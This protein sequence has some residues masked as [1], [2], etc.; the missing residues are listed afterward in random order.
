VTARLD[1]GAE[2]TLTCNFLFLC[3]GYYDYAGGYM[4][5][6]P[7]A[8]RFGKHKIIHPQLWNDT[9][10]YAG[11]RIVVIGSGA[12][13]VTLVPELA[14]KA[15]SV[16]MLQRSPTYIVSMPSVDPV[17]RWLR[18]KLP[19]GMAYDVTRFKNVSLA[20][21]IFNASRRFPVKMKE[22][23]VNQ[24]KARVGDTVDVAAHFTPTY[25]PWD[26]RL[27]LVPDADLFE[28]LRTG[29]AEIVTDHIETFT[30]HGIQLKSG[31]LLEADLV[32]S[33]TGL[34]LLFAGGMKLFVDG[35]EVDIG[36]A[37]NYKGTM[38]SDV[39]NFAV[40]LG[41][42]NASWT[43]KADLVCTYV[44][45]LLAYMDQHG[46]KQCVPRV[47]ERGEEVPLIDFSSGYV[48]RAIAHMPKQGPAAPW[49]LRQNYF[50]D[51]VGLRH[52]KIDDGVIQFSRGNAAKLKPQKRRLL[53]SAL[54]SL[55]SR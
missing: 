23:F 14:K 28:A 31:R 34:K 30:E 51:L 4:P 13:A 42:T 17:A 19:A 7:G 5:E 18:K 8:E 43:L 16:T 20:M 54:E 15:T 32:V 33:A 53:R 45:R 12:T 24:V 25:N 40:T 44:C 49:R 37:W 2:V 27:C 29:A 41:Y 47:R 38:L 35:A 52:G 46:Y 36:K 26:Q 55:R 39:P 9:V 6:W 22:L 48:Q 11:K 1:D 50:V 21:A 10:D 3:T